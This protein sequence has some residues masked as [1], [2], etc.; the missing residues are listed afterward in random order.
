[1]AAEGDDVAISSNKTF[2]WAS[3]WSEE[4]QSMFVR[5]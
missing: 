4:T 2:S 5:M 1:M 3:K